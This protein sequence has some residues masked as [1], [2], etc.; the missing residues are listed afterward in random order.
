[1]QKNVLKRFAKYLHPLPHGYQEI[2]GLLKV[3]KR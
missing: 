3:T 2:P 1:M